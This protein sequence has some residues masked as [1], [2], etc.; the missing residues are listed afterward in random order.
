MS[1]VTAQLTE[2]QAA[3]VR[4][5]V[6]GSDS[7]RAAELAGYTNPYSAACMNRQ[8]ATVQT[9][10][11]SELRRF[12]HAD[13]APAALRLVYDVMRDEKAD[14]K[15]RISCAKTVLD[16]AGFIPPKAKDE[17]AFGNKAPSEMTAEELAAASHKIARE[18]SDR[19]VTI[20]DNA[21]QPDSLSA[22]VLDM[23]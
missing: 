16:R 9:A 20:I 15:L 3:F 23:L 19:S 6:A 13:A 22:E 5:I 10:I 17:S 14:I 4:N 8:S 1:L 18:L 21:P 11:A 7:V 2:R 12:L